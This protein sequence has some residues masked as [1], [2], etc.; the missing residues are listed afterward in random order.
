M[1]LSV[2]SLFM[3]AGR[4]T[5]LKIGTLCVLFGI[6]GKGATVTGAVPRFT[7]TPPTPAFGG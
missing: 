1:T 5:V 7:P 6:T 4:E 2:S 3:D